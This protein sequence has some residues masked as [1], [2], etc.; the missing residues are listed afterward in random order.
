MIPVCVV[1]GM[2]VTQCV[3]I[4]LPCKPP[5]YLVSS[6]ALF[7][8]CLCVKS[9]TAVVFVA[10][11]QG[12]LN[13]VQWGKEVRGED[14]SDPDM[15]KAVQ[16]AVKENRSVK[17]IGIEGRNLRWTKVATAIIEGAAHNTT[18]MEVD[19][20]TPKD[21]HHTQ[22]QEVIDESRQAN[23]K[24]RLVVGAGESTSHDIT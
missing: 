19:L 12:L 6:I 16:T 10:T 18:L 7:H 4:V 21:P 17:R 2:V 1:E 3:S 23:Q 8:A 9:E 22:L 15:L 20:K 13:H 24:L 5:L 14:V 11:Q